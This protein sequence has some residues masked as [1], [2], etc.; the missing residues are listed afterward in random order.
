MAMDKG[1]LPRD[2]QLSGKIGL[3][4]LFWPCY[5]LVAA[6]KTPFQAFLARIPD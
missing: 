4:G 3:T 5:N 1:K 2:E 6:P